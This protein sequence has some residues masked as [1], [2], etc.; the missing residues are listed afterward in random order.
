VHDSNPA[1]TV[2]KM[3]AVELALVRAHIN[4]KVCVS[5]LVRPEMKNET[6]YGLMD[7]I[8][9]LHEIISRLQKIESYSL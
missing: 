8:S 4:H 5:N 9:R 3:C 1:L 2:E 7:L 6:P